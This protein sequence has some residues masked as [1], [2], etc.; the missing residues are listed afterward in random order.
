M[1]KKDDDEVPVTIRFPRGVHAGAKDAA[2]A[3]DRTL[4]S[5]VVRAVKAQLERDE[6]GRKK[7]R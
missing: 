6:E 2:E 7:V 4:N 5:Y 3:D 1:T